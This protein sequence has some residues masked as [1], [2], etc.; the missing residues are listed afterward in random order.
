MK[1]EAADDGEDE[2]KAQELAAEQERLV[3]GLISLT[4]KIITKADKVVSDR[5]IQE[6]DLIGQIFREFLFASYYEAQADNLDSDQMVIQQQI[7][8]R[9]DKKKATAPNNRSREAAYELLHQLIK[10]SSTL[11]KTF[12]DQNLVPLIMTIKKP[13]TFNYIPS[14]SGERYQKYVGLRNLGCICYM[15]SMMQQFFMIP[16]FRYN[17]L[18]IDDGKA[19]EIKEY[20]GEQIDDNMMHQ[21]QNLIAHL[22]LSERNDFN[23]MAF[24]FSFKEFDGSPTNTAEQKDAQEFLNVIFDRIENALKPTSRKHLVQG[25]FGGK[26]CS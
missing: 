1:K 2:I 5:I 11:M 4:G 3:T 14:T 8:S 20:K 13:K 6:K 23:P 21:V 9:T 24:C 7:G 22:E 12:L 17:L 18:C 19:E 10:G 26:S 25:I 16:A 15:N